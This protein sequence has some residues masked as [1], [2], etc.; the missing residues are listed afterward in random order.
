MS[1]HTAL[2]TPADARALLGLS[3]AASIEERSRAFRKAAKTATLAG[4]DAALRR[5]IQARDILA[6]QCPRLALPG[7]RVRA[8]PPPSVGL[9]PAQ[10][11]SG[12]VVTVTLA[13]R[14]RVRLM[15]P[16]GLRTG[17]H[18]RLRGAGASG[19]DLFLPV[20]VRP[21]DGLTVV[22][23][24]VYMSWPASPRLLS[25]GGR[26]EIATHA[27][28]RGAWVAPGATAPVQ[29]CLRGLG[30]PARGGRPAGRLYVRL[31][32]AADTPSAAEDLLARFHRVWTPERLAA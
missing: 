24:D 26:V 19:E 12:G 6:A 7:P 17:E 10:A 13:R 22:G 23:D 1:A 14:R 4:D 9:T 28:L 30:L 3:E 25:D 20:V 5:A 8:A 21:S 18:L 31:E 16:P 29:L 32:P 2:L 11:L 27:G 15:V